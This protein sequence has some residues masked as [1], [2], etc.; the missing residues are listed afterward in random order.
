[1]ASISIEMGRISI[2]MAAISSVFSPKSRPT[3]CIFPDA[4]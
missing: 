2:E 3:G 4:V 1:M